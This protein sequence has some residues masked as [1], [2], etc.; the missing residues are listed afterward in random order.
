MWFINSYRKVNNFFSSPFR[1]YWILLSICWN[2]SEEVKIYDKKAHIFEL[3]FYFL[4]S[5][6]WLEKSIEIKIFRCIGIVG[7]HFQHDK[8]YKT[9]FKYYMVYGDLIKLNKMVTLRPQRAIA[10]QG[11]TINKISEFLP[12]YP[13]AYFHKICTLLIFS[14]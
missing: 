14:K 4:Q 12:L 13:F 1:F 2:T 3:Q 5:S 8:L 6:K 10:S 7:K 11:Y 9:P